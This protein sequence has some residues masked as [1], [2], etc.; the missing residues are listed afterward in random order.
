MAS[1]EQVADYLSATALVA[2]RV[3]NV[4]SGDDLRQAANVLR[5]LEREANA[6]T[7]KD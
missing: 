7:E 2:D 3:L 4:A 6:K 1:T 5:R